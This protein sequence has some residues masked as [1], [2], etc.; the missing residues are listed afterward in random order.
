MGSVAGSIFWDH[1]IDEELRCNYARYKQNDF[2]NSTQVYK[3]W[4]QNNDNCFPKF[5]CGYFATGGRSV[6]RAQIKDDR[7]NNHEDKPRHKID[8]TLSLKIYLAI[9]LSVFPPI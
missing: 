4:S 2:G 5:V 1:K 6:F 9:K 3:N 8:F 7:I